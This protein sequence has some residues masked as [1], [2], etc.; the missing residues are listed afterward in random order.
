MISWQPISEFELAAL[1]KEVVA[2]MTDKEKRY[3]DAV[4]IYPEK[5]HE[6]T[7]GAQGGGVWVVGLLGKNVLWYNDI[8][9]GFNVSRFS[10]YGRLDEYWAN[11]D[12][13]LSIIRRFV[14]HLEHGK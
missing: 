7:Y 9:D 11:Q 12:D 6:E 3:W 5:W 14:W 8:E 13:L 4:K 1:L 2:G 10:E